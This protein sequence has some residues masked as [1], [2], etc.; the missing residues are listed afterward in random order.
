MDTFTADP[1]AALRENAHLLMDMATQAGLPYMT[2]RLAAI[3]SLAQRLGGAA[4]PSG[5]GGGDC[6]IALFS[7]PEATTT[8]VQ[9]C[10][11]NGWPVIPIR[12]CFGAQRTS[13]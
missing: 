3:T 6:A 5:A 10:A 4:K 1:V 2:P 11:E 12:P 8:F 7:D 9:T 13:G